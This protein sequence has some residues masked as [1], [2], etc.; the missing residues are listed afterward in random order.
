MNEESV[1][2]VDSYSLFTNQ[3]LINGYAEI[4]AQNI[5]EQFARVTNG[6]TPLPF[7]AE[8]FYR[9]LFCFD[10]F[11]IGTVEEDFALLI[12][13][14][15][16]AYEILK[17]GWLTLLKDFSAD[18][19]HQSAHQ[20]LDVRKLVDRIDAYLGMLY[21]CYFEISKELQHQQHHETEAIP[22]DILAQLTVAG[23]NDDTT[24]PHTTIYTTF[25][26]IPIERS[27]SVISATPEA[28]IFKVEPRLRAALQHGHGMAVIDCHVRE[29]CYRAT[30]NPAIEAGNAVA[31][32]AL[33]PL[34]SS[35]KRK[36]IRVEPRSNVTVSLTGDTDGI[37]ARL[38]DISRKSATLYCRSG[39]SEMLVEGGELSMGL[40]LPLTSAGTLFSLNCKV[41]IRRVISHYRK[42][43]YA[44]RISV[45]LELDPVHSEMLANYLTTRQSE[46]LA[47]LNGYAKQ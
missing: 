28:L 20:L 40:E 6:T 41:S 19:L 27:G 11:D 23:S 8:E 7:D 22:D 32:S 15:P 14:T 46:I 29:K 31:F 35:F 30:F 43:P 3:E 42:D 25:M 38:I 33:T 39:A 47:Q 24:G 18:L 26:G 13:I 34:G 44:Y 12:R 1:E 45:D 21:D 10:V 16:N 37:E 36:H 17:H 4:F 5:T 2:T 9:Q